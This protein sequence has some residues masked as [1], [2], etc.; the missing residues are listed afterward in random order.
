[1]SIWTR[2]YL[3]QHY[4]SFSLKETEVVFLETKNLVVFLVAASILFGF[5][6]K[7]NVFTI[8]ISNLLL[9]FGAKGDG[10]YESWY[11]YTLF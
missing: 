2:G 9:P 7:L 10:G 11:K 1:M 5:C 6:F 3:F 8:K 4:R